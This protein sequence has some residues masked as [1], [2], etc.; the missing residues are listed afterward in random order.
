MH[1]HLA[2]WRTAWR[3]WAIVAAAVAVAALG[4]AEGPPEAHGQAA[5]ATST[6]AST[7]P[8]PTAASTQPTPVPGPIPPAPPVVH[9]SRYFPQTSFRI[10]HDPFWDYFNARG[11]VRTFGYPVSRT[12]LFLGCT[13]QFFQR[14]L[15]QQCGTGPVQLMNLLDPDLMPYN[16]I[17]FSV[18]P[19]HDPAVASGAPAPG[20]PNYGQAVL[21]YVRSVAPDTFEGQNVRFYTT[22]VTTVPGVDPSTDP[23]TAALVN[24]EIWGFP[25]SNPQFDPTNRGFVYQRFQR[26]I[27]HFDAAS[28]ATQ[29]ILL[30]DYFKSI[31]TGRN[32]PPDLAA[33]A[34]GSRFLNQYC[35]GAPGWVCRPSQL[36]A[37]DLTF[38]FETG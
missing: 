10:D 38:A 1:S 24:L 31:I 20:T 19:A 21:N 17:N 15:M 8:T 4:F 13:T 18:F 37:T 27:M 26:G 9:D 35:P 33:Q 3:A 14:Q 5:T 28:G 12:F 36:P 11:S 23:D 16:Q 34:V 29:G 2:Q 22:F 7:A 25:T 6:A 30:S 32:L